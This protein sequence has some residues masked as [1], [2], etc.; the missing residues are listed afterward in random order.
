[1]RR[2]SSIDE[3]YVSSISEASAVSP[4][5]PSGTGH[6][7]TV[8][9]GK[10]AAPPPSAQPT[11]AALAEDLA[12]PARQAGAH[13][14]LA[15]TAAS[16]SGQ[17][18]ICDGILFH[19]NTPVLVEP[20]G[21]QL[22]RLAGLSRALFELRRQGFEFEPFVKRALPRDVSEPSDLWSRYQAF[23]NLTLPPL[24]NSADH[25]RWRLENG[26]AAGL[27][28][29]EMRELR[30]TLM[31]GAQVSRFAAS[32][33]SLL[34][35]TM[36]DGCGWVSGFTQL[37]TLPANARE[38]VARQRQGPLFRDYAP[39][40]LADL[41]DANAQRLYLDKDG[42]P[43]V[44]GDAIIEKNAWEFLL[45]GKVTFE[46]EVDPNTIVTRLRMDYTHAAPDTENVPVELRMDGLPQIMKTGLELAHLF[47]NAQER[48]IDLIELCDQTNLEAGDVLAEW[49]PRID[50]RLLAR[51]S[52]GCT[53]WNK[54]LANHTT[55]TRSLD[56]QTQ[57]DLGYL[58]LDVEC[59][60]SAFCCVQWALLPIHVEKRWHRLALRHPDD[61]EVRFA[62]HLL[63]E[64]S[65]PFVRQDFAEVSDRVESLAA[66][67]GYFQENRV[68]SP[69]VHRD[70]I[71]AVARALKM[72]VQ[73]DYEVETSTPTEGSASLAS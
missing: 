15:A 26:R 10:P 53:D 9:S 27:S 62:C 23:Q 7:Q 73:G 22:R 21:D 37:L 20:L 12:M 3:L 40:S 65:A 25:L 54:E 55:G 30:G 60:V 5:I 49:L 33:T 63:S 31:Q 14:D 47:E 71:K 67:L 48:G 2:A 69:W 11:K 42:D 13:P 29:E 45:Q 32:L 24:A 4:E 64:K 6:Q 59:L 41:L 56:P 35:Q 72:V 43:V 68:S 16:F 70:E 61:K 44:R 52:E 39:E 17:A 1:M 38:L 46:T 58:L 57:A 66:F 8:G 34:Y 28:Q 50:L 36:L 19:K 51:V 18:W